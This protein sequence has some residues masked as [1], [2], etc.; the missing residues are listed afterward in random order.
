VGPP[1]RRSW[2]NRNWKWALPVGCL[3]AVLL[4]A[5]GFA[6]FFFLIYSVVSGTITSSDAYQEGMAAA[7]SSPEV[8][9]ALGEP[10]GSG[11]WITGGIEVSGPSGNVNVAIPIF[12]PKGSGTLYVVGIRTAGRWQ[13]STMEVEIPGR[14]DRIDLMGRLLDVPLDRGGH[15]V[16][17]AQ[18]ARDRR[19]GA[20]ARPAHAGPAVALAPWPA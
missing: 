11:F 12:G 20:A 2:V 7:R 9:A 17:G 1:P 4:A 3:L 8:R 14:S 16:A 19:G 10:I 5:G 13:Y 15:R 18:A 6:V